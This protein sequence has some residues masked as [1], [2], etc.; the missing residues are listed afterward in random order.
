[1]DANGSTI[2]VTGSGV[3]SAAPDIADVRLGVRVAR[4]SAVEARAEAAR[5]MAAVLAALRDAGAAS[6]DI[7]T[8]ALSLEPQYD[9]SR[10]GGAPS[11]VGY[12]VTNLVIVTVRDLERLGVVVDGGLAAGATSLD[13][14][15]FGIADPA[16]LETV[17]RRAAVADARLK[18]E[19]L[20]AAAGV[21]ITGIHSIDEGGSAVPVPMSTL[22]RAMDT[23]TPI[24]P[25]TTEVRVAV[26]IVFS[27]G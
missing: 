13:G 16:A 8:T 5:T 12:E 17:A 11:A 2:S 26:R 24:A 15:S 9:P 1:M 27:V 19:D 14:L 3:A 7:R 6:A 4:E 22:A 20:A 23:G 21:S 18:A 25:G 10:S